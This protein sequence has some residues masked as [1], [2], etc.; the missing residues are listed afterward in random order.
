MAVRPSSHRSRWASKPAP[1]PSRFTSGED[2][3]PLWMMKSVDA[4]G[5]LTTPF[6]SST[7]PP[8]FYSATLGKP[9]VDTA[10]AMSFVA[11]GLRLGLTQPLN[12][13]GI[14][15]PP[16]GVA[17]RLTASPENLPLLHDKRFTISPPVGLQAPVGKARNLR[18][19]RCS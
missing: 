14:P 19:R 1:R 16:S 12:Y 9:A 7:R 4:G 15:S 5:F 18:T 10:T 17:G 3:L 2:S 8:F 13:C 6:T 11:K